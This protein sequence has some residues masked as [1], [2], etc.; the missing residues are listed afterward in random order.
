MISV[1]E[2]IEI[3]ADVKNQHHLG[4]T[5]RKLAVGSPERRYGQIKTYHS[6]FASDQEVLRP[7]YRYGVKR[8]LKKTMQLGAYV[9]E[10]GRQILQRRP[11]YAI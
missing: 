10:L 7:K 2:D 9:K 1:M 4:T 3:N 5:L 8:F 11:I 6:R